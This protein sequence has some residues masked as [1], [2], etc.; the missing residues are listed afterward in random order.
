MVNAEDEVPQAVLLLFYQVLQKYSSILLQQYVLIVLYELVGAGKQKKK[1]RQIKETNNNKNNERRCIRSTVNNCLRTQPIKYL[2]SQLL[3]YTT[4][5]T[6]QI[7]IPI[8]FM[9]DMYYI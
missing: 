1:T 4:V 9:I 6:A 8:R 2:C 5:S 3:L 7:R